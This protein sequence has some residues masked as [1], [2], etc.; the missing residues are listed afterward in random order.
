MP[1]QC[2]VP[3]TTCLFKLVMPAIVT[4]VMVQPESK[5]CQ[6]SP[7][8]VIR[9][10]HKKTQCAHGLKSRNASVIVINTSEYSKALRYANFG[11]KSISVAQKTVNL[12]I[13]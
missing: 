11:P 2:Y 6:S 5:K 9:V 1:D 13:I 8:C 10:E 7:Y 12:E 4:S 3:Q